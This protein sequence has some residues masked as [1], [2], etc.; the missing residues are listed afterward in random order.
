MTKKEIIIIL[1][2]TLGELQD[3]SG[4]AQC[5]ITPK[6]IPIGGLSGFDSLRALELNTMLEPRLQKSIDDFDLFRNANDNSP[7]TVED[8]ADKLLHL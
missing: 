5:D 6:T 1:I 7:L 2:A 4:E 3:L 8:V